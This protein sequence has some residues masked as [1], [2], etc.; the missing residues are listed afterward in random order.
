MLIDYHTHHK[1]CGHAVGE[2]RQY[3]EQAIRIGVNEIGLS[4][5]MPIIH[6][7]KEK[8]LPGMAMELNELEKYV[9]EALDL[10]KVYKNDI[11][12]KVGL[13]ADYIKGY[14]D[15]IVDLLEPYPFDYLI[16]SVHFLGEWDFSDSRH[17]YG[18][19]QRDID[20]IYTEYFLTVQ[21]LAKSGIYDIIGH[22]DV[23][24]KYGHRPKNDMTEII[25][26]TLDVIKQSDMAME[27][28]T[29]GLNK[30]VEEIY[31]ASNI[32]EKAVQKEIPF[33]LGSDA[34]KPESVHERLDVG[35]KL[36]QQL[37]VNKL[38]TFDQRK[39]FMVTF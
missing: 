22:F 13:E 23:I 7:S 18:W 34:H 24:K 26:T 31:P 32:V 5:H 25:G 1:R 15:R 6:L 38:A 27:I 3:I 30:V 17:M 14:E 12:I 19:Q 33:T 21:S 37:G 9:Q 16:G 39:R 35:R 36:L 2:L 8:I 28:N 20:E 4:D 10:K 29:S 11:N